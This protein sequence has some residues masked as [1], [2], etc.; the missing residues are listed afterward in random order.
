[1]VQARSRS[2]TWQGACPRRQRPQRG[3]SPVPSLL[4]RAGARHAPGWLTPARSR[5]ILPRA[6]RA[7][8]AVDLPATIPPEAALK[9]RPQRAPDKA[10]LPNRTTVK[11]RSGGRG[12]V[13]WSGPGAVVSIVNAGA[14]LPAPSRHSP[15]TASTGEPLNSKRHFVFGV[16]L[17][18]NSKNADAGMR[19]R[20]DL[21]KLRPSERTLNT[22]APPE[23]A[24]AKPHRISVSSTVLPAARMIGAVSLTR[25]SSAGKAE[26]DRRLRG[27]PNAPPPSRR[28][29]PSIRYGARSRCTWAWTAVRP[30]WIRG[31][32]RRLSISGA[33]SCPGCRCLRAS[34][35]PPWSNPTQQFS[36]ILQPS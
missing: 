8:A 28:N 7:R 22:G 29:K 32:A 15:A 30:G 18:V 10:S 27:F 2:A 16:A 26:T 6:R 4:G 20:L 23:R 25:V 5:P 31:G 19:H 17:P 1:M 24:G 9:V 36:G 11:L 12:T 13:R 21:A 14:S 3:R 33:R 35:N 34:V